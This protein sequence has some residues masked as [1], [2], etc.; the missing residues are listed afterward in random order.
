MDTGYV[1][2]P[3]Q[4][5]AAVNDGGTGLEEIVG[6]VVEDAPATDDFSVQRPLYRLRQNP[7]AAHDVIVI[8]K[9]IVGEVTIE[10]AVEPLIGGYPQ[11]VPSVNEQCLDEVETARQLG[12]AGAV[13]A[14]DAMRIGYEHRPVLCGAYIE[15]IVSLPVVVGCT[16]HG[17]VAINGI[18]AVLSEGIERVTLAAKRIEPIASPYQEE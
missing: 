11:A 4:I 5:D 10:E 17:T 16:Q 3:G 8:V 7:D 12:Y 9:A 2:S 15:A 1:V 18:D 6:V 14:V 13:I